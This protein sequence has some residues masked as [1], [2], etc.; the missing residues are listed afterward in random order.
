MS[1]TITREQIYEAL[2]DLPKENALDEAIERL[3]FIAG[4]REGLDQAERGEGIVHEDVRK[5]IDKWF[6]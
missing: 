2:R 1:D 6:E 3:V 5:M 4:I